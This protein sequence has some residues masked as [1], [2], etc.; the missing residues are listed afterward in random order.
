MDFH[1]KAAVAKESAILPDAM[2]ALAAIP[3]TCRLFHEKQESRHP[4][5][6]YNT[7][8][9]N[10]GLRLRRVLETLLDQKSIVDYLTTRPITVN[11]RIT[12]A[13]R[14]AC[15]QPPPPMLQV[16]WSEEIRQ[17]PGGGAFSNPLPTR[18]FL[19]SPS[20]SFRSTTAPILA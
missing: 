12:G 8:L 19:S 3:E 1:F 2:I 18:L 14:A 5:A 16:P 20:S 4:F 11:K 15:R 13:R 6:L 10:V 17:P 9:W 7:S